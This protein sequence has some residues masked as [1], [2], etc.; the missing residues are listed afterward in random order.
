[1]AHISQE[2]LASQIKAA[3]TQVQVGGRYMHY[4]DFTKTYVVSGLSV[5]EADDS[6]AVVYEADYG[7]KLSFVRPLASWLS[8]AEHEGK[9]VSRFTLIDD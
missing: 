5:L 4:K 9:T 2:E 1:V 3:A 8:R 6:I 7:E